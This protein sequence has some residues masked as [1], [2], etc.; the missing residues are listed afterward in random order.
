MAN[1]TLSSNQDFLDVIDLDSVLKSG[2]GGDYYRKSKQTQ[3]CPGTTAATTERYN[4][5]LDSVTDDELRFVTRSLITPV[6]F[7]SHGTD[8]RL[9]PPVNAPSRQRNRILPRNNEHLAQ[10]P[11]FRSE[12]AAIFNRL[13]GTYLTLHQTTCTTCSCLIV[14]CITYR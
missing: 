13:A 14:L 5:S 10:V 7:Q 2:R 4:I 6:S 11:T 12:S 8:D 3:T 9:F 1:S